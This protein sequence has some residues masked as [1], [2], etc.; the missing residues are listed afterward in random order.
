MIPAR[1]QQAAGTG[2]IGG[3]M[4]QAPDQQQDPQQP[5][6]PQGQ[7]PQP[8]QQGGG[9]ERVVLAAMKILYEKQPSDSIVKMLRSGD[10]A[11]ALAQ[12]ALFVMKVLYDE[13]KGSIPA[14]VIVPAAGSVVQ[15]LA[16]LA[17]AAKIELSD[18][19]VQQVAATVQQRIQERFK[20]GKPPVG[21]PGQ[22]QAA[23]AGAAAA[24]PEGAVPTPAGP[25]AAAEISQPAAAAAQQD[26]GE[27]GEGDPNDPDKL[28]ERGV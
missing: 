27:P 18:E 1:Q 10:P 11:Q 28:K 20:N 19:Q 8:A 26:V 16:E 15:L 7:Q 2:L 9:T 17:R 13:S 3:V 5:Q 21:M 6:A 14:E 25:P 12:T 4:A 22:Q 24:G 23:P